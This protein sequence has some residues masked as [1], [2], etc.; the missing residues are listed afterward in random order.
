MELTLTE[1]LYSVTQYSPLT[2]SVLTK[3][4]TDMT[5]RKS[6]KRRGRGSVGRRTVEGSKRTFIR[7]S[8]LCRLSNRALQAP[9]VVCRSMVMELKRIEEEEGRK[10][11]R[12]EEATQ[13]ASMVM[14][15][16]FRV[17][18]WVFSFFRLQQHA[19]FVFF[20]Y[21][22]LF[23]FFFKNRIL[24]FQIGGFTLP[25]LIF[26]NGLLEPVAFSYLLQRFYC[27]RC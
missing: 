1:S 25:F 18:F 5:K 10:R 23:H 19:S 11:R 14:E 27:T 3:T 17:C 20:F 8:V 21:F 6:S 24:F 12:E 26:C 2:N 7:L 22:F 15:S 9:T 4:R 13:R 16:K